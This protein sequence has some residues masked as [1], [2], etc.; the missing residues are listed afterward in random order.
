MPTQ[1]FVRRLITRILILIFLSV[2]IFTFLAAASAITSNY[3]AAGQMENNDELFII[4]EMYN[5]FFRPTLITA[6]VLIIIYNVI[7]I[8]ITIYKFIRSK[9]ENI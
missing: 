4:H 6:F 5:K 2:F 7:Q 8:S 9:K 3:I 1:K